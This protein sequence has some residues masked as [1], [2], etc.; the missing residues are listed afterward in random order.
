MSP[1]PC[2]TWASTSWGAMGL[3]WS[4]MRQSGNCFPRDFRSAA[5]V[6]KHNMDLSTAEARDI[7]MKKV[8][9]HQRR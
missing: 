8:V 5:N 7:R 4:A 1:L 2:K 3:V 9:K 6:A